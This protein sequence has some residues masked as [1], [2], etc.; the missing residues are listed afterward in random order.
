V[1]GFEFKCGLAIVFRLDAFVL[2]FYQFVQ[3]VYKVVE[4]LVVGSYL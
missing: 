3:L 2:F 1:G 4:Y